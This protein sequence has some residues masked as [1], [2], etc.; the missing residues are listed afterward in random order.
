MATLVQLVQD[1]S[2]L[3]SYIDVLRAFAV[4][5]TLLVPLTLILLPAVEKRTVQVSE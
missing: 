3:L 2:S 1:Q 5:A 4:V